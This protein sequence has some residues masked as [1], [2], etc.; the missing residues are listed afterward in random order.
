MFERI[1]EIISNSVLSHN[2]LDAAHHNLPHNLLVVRLP[3]VLT[4][5][6]A[7]RLMPSPPAR[8][9]SKKTKMSERLWKSATMSRR[10]EILDEPSSRMYVCLRCHMY[11][12]K[13]E[14]RVGL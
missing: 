8:V 4:V 5:S 10:S 7:V 14:T 6:A 3:P 12:W 1:H 11:S 13:S 2:L 9:D